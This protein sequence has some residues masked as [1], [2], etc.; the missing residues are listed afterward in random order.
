MLKPAQ[1]HSESNVTATI[2]GVWRD[3]CVPSSPE[4]VRIGSFVRIDLTSPAGPCGAVISEWTSHATLG[5]FDPGLYR[6]GVFV[7]GAFYREA[8]LRVAEENPPIG[9]TLTAGPEKGGLE[10]SIITDLCYAPQ[11]EPVSITFGGVPA[12]KIRQGAP[13]FW[14]IATVPPHAAGAVD[15]TVSN[16]FQ[17]VTE[18]AAFV[19]FD[20]DAPP[21]YSFFEPILFPFLAETTG[22]YGSRWKTEAILANFSAEV[23]LVTQRQIDAAGYVPT[24]GY[25]VM[26]NPPQY[27]RG[28]VWLPLRELG[29][30]AA[31]EWT[32][33]ETTHGSAFEL[34]S[35]RESD[36]RAGVL[37][38]AGIPRDPARYRV[39]L[40]IYSLD[41]PNPFLQQNIEVSVSG[42]ETYIPR[43][44]TH[45]TLTRERDDE[46]YFA[47][48]PDLY[49]IPLSDLGVPGS[50]DSQLKV[51]L[52]SG[53]Q[54]MWAVVSV[55][56]NQTQQTRIITPL[57]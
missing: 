11:C 56:D 18:R 32:V 3:A 44:G 46:P 52:L 22:G 25:R 51:I 23:P 37:V 33:R 2:K 41:D 34:P 54:R 14:L 27:P 9:M 20:E 39:T 5:Y 12:T 19:Y 47:I 35:V 24:Q 7:N 26:K 28:L 8:T 45:I 36:F 17:S 49:A 6:V 40:R 50:E 42:L 4:V 53:F 55:V 31:A 10:T 15:V 43:G 38:L 21:D 57:K 13:S 30:S 16:K 1:P 29:A 48:I